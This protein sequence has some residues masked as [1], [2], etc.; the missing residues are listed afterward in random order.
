MPSFNA[1]IRR[2]HRAFEPPTG[3][4]LQRSHQMKA[5]EPLNRELGKHTADCELGKQQLQSLRYPKD[6]R[7]AY[8]KPDFGNEDDKE[9]RGARNGNNHESGT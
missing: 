5:C 7:S 1:R 8:P 6:E 9:L 2:K 4:K 3:A